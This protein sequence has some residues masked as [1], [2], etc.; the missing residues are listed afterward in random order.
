MDSLKK[1]Y[2]L[3]KPGMVYGNLITAGAGYFLASRLHLRLAS[4]LAMVVGVALLMGAACAFNNIIDRDIDILMQ[5]T[6]SRPSAVGTIS[7]RSGM[8]FVFTLVLT[9]SLLLLLGVNVLTFVIGA[10]GF[11]DYALVYTFLK[12]KTRFSTLIG[13]IAGATPI[14]GGYT[15]YAGHITFSALLAGLMMLFWQMPHFYAL[16]LY[17]EKDYKKARIPLLPIVK[18]HRSTLREM[19]FYNVLFSIAVFGLYFNAKLGWAYLL[20]LGSASLAWL[21][22]NLK[23]TLKS[24]DLTSWA[25][26]SFLYSLALVVLMSLMVALR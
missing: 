23:G 16:A 12:R 24:V 7:F 4:F 1:Y 11:I 13:S 3:S 17:R 6:K 22:Y 26:Q 5:R 19:I 20:I 18:G 10:V 15:A 25:K 9:A 8:T 14:I 21:G 2:R